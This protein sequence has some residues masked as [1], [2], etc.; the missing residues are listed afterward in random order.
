MSAKTN[1]SKVEEHLANYESARR[2]NM[3]SIKTEHEIALINLAN[4]EVEKYKDIVSKDPYRLN[5]HI[6]PPVGLLNDPN[7]FIHFKGVYHLFYQ[8]N[9]FETNHGAK[10]WGHYTSTDLVHWELQPIALAPSEWYEKNGCYSGSAVQHEGK[11]FLFYTGNVKDDE[12]NRK[13]YQCLAVSEDGIHF[14]KKGP[15]I[16]LPKGYTA[17]F[18]D[19]KVWRKGDTWYL[20]IGAQSEKEEGRVVLFTSKDLETWKYLGPITGSNMNNLYEFGYMW[21]CPDLFDLDGQDVLIVSPQ[22]LKPKGYLYN[23]LYQAGYFVGKMDYESV[24]FKHGEFVELDRGFDFYAPQTTL[25]EKGRRILFGWMGVPEENEPYHPTIYH[26]WIHC[27]TI[28]RKL[29]LKG[30]KLYQMPVEELQNLREGEV[31]YTGIPLSGENMELE[32]VNGKSVEILIDSLTNEYE[33]FE[34]CFRH[35]ARFIYNASKKLATFERESLKED[36]KIEAR[37]CELESLHKIHIYLDTS[38]VE[39]FLNG[40]EEVFS[41]RIFGD[42]TDESIVFSSKGDI[43]FNL[44]KWTLKKVFK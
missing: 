5:Y 20:V 41:S 18:R 19:P 37:H 22:G 29:E 23:N 32:H 12:G 44:K 2:I 28:P 26:H 31:S 38:S 3:K 36:K 24:R 14:E 30:G 43:R 9:P 39:I 4:D 11:M 21:E 27:M 8:W 40:G 16:H 34:I 15:V 13:T 17:H 25:D 42:V 7:G 6:M 35:H 10:F 1:L 33:K